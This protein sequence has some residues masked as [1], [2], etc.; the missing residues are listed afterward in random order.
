MSAAGGACFVNLLKSGREGLFFRQDIL[1]F[2]RKWG[3]IKHKFHGESNRHGKGA[4]NILSA[5][6]VYF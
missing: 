6:A 1:T 4:E 5:L 3:K 2:Q